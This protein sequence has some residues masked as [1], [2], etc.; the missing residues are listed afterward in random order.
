VI[1]SWLD[2][3]EV[4][5]SREGVQT[6]GKRTQRGTEHAGDEDT[7][8][9]HQMPHNVLNEEWHQFVWFADQ[10]RRKDIQYRLF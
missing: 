8:H 3:V 6:G 1:D 5:H 9:A 2:V 4:N 10:L 7:G